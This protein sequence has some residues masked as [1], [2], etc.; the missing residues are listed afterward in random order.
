[1]ETTEQS[2]SEQ[3]T[4][5]NLHIVKNRTWLEHYKSCPVINTVRVFY[6]KRIRSPQLQEKVKTVVCNKYFCPGLFLYS[7][8]GNVVRPGCHLKSAQEIEM[9]VFPSFFFHQFL[10]RWWKLGPEVPETPPPPL[11]PRGAVRA[12]ALTWIG[13]TM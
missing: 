7:K 12:R 6:A 4:R 11:P 3:C 2:D 13:F 10:P 8:S 9:E 1:M 5:L